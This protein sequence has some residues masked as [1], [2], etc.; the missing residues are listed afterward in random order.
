MD[1][2]ATL[3]IANSSNVELV[4]FYGLAILAI[5]LAFGVI[6]DRVI[7]REDD[8]LRGRQPGEI[9]EL[10]RATILQP[11]GTYCPASPNGLPPVDAQL[12]WAE[13]ECEGFMRS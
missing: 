10:L 1:Q 6:F 5:P 4:L 2:V 7:I 8:D 11:N 3:N 13:G 12:A 9:A